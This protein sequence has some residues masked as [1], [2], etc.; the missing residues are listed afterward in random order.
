MNTTNTPTID[1]VYNRLQRLCEIVNNR[2]A[3]GLNDDDQVKEMFD[4][5]KKNLEIVRVAIGYD[6]YRAVKTDFV[7]GIIKKYKEEKLS[8]CDVKFS[9]NKKRGKHIG[10][11][12]SYSKMEEEFKNENG[13]GCWGGYTVWVSMEEYDLI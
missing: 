1:S 4:F 13:F 8:L 10:I 6:K 11:P 5:A 9:D 7:K 2:Y 12:L 3:K